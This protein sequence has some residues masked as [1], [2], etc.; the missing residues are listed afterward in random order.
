MQAGGVPRGLEIS[1][2]LIPGRSEAKGK[3][4]QNELSAGKTAEV[5]VHTLRLDSLLLRCA[6]AGNDKRGA[7]IAYIIGILPKQ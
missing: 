3:G 5:L 4:I 1:F 6:T 2:D 7:S